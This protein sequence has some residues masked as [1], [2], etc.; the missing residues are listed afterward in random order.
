MRC[1]FIPSEDIVNGFSGYTPSLAA[2]SGASGPLASTG[3]TLSTKHRDEV[4]TS[5]NSNV[6]IVHGALAVIVAGVVILA[7]GR[8]YLRNAR[9]A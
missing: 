1:S 6:H 5:A 9:I 8:G 3:E 2:L 7:I 4:A